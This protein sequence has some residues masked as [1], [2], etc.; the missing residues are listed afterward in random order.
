MADKNY[1]DLTC[2]KGAVH[3]SLDA[4]A[5]LASGTA[6]DAGAVGDLA[7]VPQSQAKGVQVRAGEAGCLVDV[8][9]LVCQNEN[10][11]EAAKSV[12]Q[13]VK[14]ALES[15]TK[16]PVQEVNVFVDGVSTK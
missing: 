11:S 16:V 1:Y 2:D 4:I 12:Q 15:V 3:L 7:A 8:H 5:N 13:L 9:I 10:M 6:K 14:E